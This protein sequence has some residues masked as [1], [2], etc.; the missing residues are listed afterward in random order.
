MYTLLLLSGG[1]GTRMHNTVPKQYMLLAGKPVIMHILERVDQ[2]DRISEV[3]VVC[4]NEYV[5]SIELM[6]NQYGVSK[7]VRFAPAGA[8]RQASVRSG[9]QLVRTDDVLLHESARPFVKVED[10]NR[11]LDVEQRN[12]TYGLSIPF[13]VLQGHERVEGI[14]NRSELFNVQLPQKFE[15]RLIREAHERALAEG[16]EFTEDAGMVFRYFPGTEIAI[17]E[18]M[19]YD[20]K[21]TTHIDMLAGEQIYDEIFRRRK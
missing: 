4:A 15:T 9:L 21:L 5:S 16:V 20:I 17:C 10:F 2:I 19:D 8:T 14:L 3:V 7:P 13:S 6:L 11:L 18:G 1:V 12:A